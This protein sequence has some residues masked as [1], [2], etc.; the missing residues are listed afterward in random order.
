VRARISRCRYACL[1]AAFACT[2]PLGVAV[3]TWVDD[4]LADAGGVTKVA[5]LAALR[6]IAAGTFLYVAVLELLAP[7]FGHQHAHGAQPAQTSSGGGAGG[8][9]G[10]LE[11]LIGGGGGAH[12]AGAPRSQ[13]PPRAPL[14]AGGGNVN[15]LAILLAGYA[16]MAALAAWM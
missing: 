7:A 8:R 3:G 13:Q 1:A 14:P 2:T 12:D 11:P 9:G 6:A 16:A 10:L 15:D 5:D 4:S